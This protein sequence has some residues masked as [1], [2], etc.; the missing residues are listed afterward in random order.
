M[1]F[2]KFRTCVN[3]TIMEYYIDIINTIMEYYINIINTIMEDYI[4]IIKFVYFICTIYI[5]LPYSIELVPL[6]YNL[7]YSF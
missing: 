3:N 7:L 4:D 6:S 5:H 1:D 2:K